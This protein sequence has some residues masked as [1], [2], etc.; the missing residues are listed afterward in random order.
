[1]LP[2]TIGPGLEN[3]VVSVQQ[4]SNL[5]L[6]ESKHLPIET[7]AHKSRLVYNITESPTNGYILVENKASF[8]F[9]QDQL[10]RQQIKYMQTNMNRSSDEFKVSLLQ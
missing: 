3:D 7:N 4:G 2:I 5:A 6:I 10:M 9:N 1:M 8:R